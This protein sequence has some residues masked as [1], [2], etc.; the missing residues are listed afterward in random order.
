MKNLV[1]TKK[2]LGLIAGALFAF[3]LLFNTSLATNENGAVSL[4]LSKLEIAK[5]QDDEED[6]YCYDYHIEYDCG[7]MEPDED[8]YPVYIE[9]YC[10]ELR[11]SCDEY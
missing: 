10:Y 11:N 1:N 8:G 2:V 6:D 5:A 4:S 7:Y 3:A 9:A